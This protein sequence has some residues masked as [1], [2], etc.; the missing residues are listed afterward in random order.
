MVGIWGTL[1][2]PDSRR[3]VQWTGLPSGLNPEG[4]PVDLAEDHQSVL[5]KQKSRVRGPE[6]SGNISMWTHEQK[7]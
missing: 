5:T 3:A 4:F 6:V 1:C 2:S 7:V